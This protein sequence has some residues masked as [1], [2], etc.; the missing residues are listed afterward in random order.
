MI[1]ENAEIMKNAGE[2]IVRGVELPPLGELETKDVT[3][4][5]TRDSQ[6]D[7]G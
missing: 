5:T 4:K 6:K 1:R 7:A 2:A 3:E